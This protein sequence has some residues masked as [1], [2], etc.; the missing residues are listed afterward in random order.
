M[1]RIVQEIGLET[2]RQLIDFSGSQKVQ[3]HVWKEQLEGA[4][5]I[6]NI[7][8]REKVAYLADEVGMGKTYVALGVVGLF[9]HF[10][11]GW[12][13]LYI[14]PRENIQR[15]WHKEILNFTAN[16]WLVTDNRVRSFQRTPAYGLAV[17]HNLLDLTHQVTINPHRD[18]LTRMTSFSL[19]L[20]TNKYE[21][22]DNKRRALFQEIPWLDH[23]LFDLRDKEQFK[24]NYARAINAVLPYFDL[25]IIDEGHN[26]KHGLQGTAA[27]N[28]LI[29]QVLGHSILADR[30]FPNYG[31][32]FERVLILS[33]TPLESDYRELWNQLHLFDSHLN[34]STLNETGSDQ[35]TEEAKQAAVSRF[36]VRRLTGLTIGEKKHTKNMYRREWRNGGVSSHDHP[37][38]VADERQRLIVALV[39]KK[40][41]EIIGSERFKNSFQIGM[42]ASFESFLETAKV[43]DDSGNFDGSDQT[44]EQL[45]K[46]GIDTPSINRLAESYRQ[47]F[48]EALPHPKMDAVAESLKQNFETGEKVLI[49]V[50]R[51]RSVD[52]LAEKLN[53]YYDQWLKEYLIS[54]SENYPVIQQELEAA[55]QRYNADRL[56]RQSLSYGTTAETNQPIEENNQSV[57]KDVE[58]QGDIDNFFAWFFRGEGPSDFFSGASFNRN[59][60]TSEGSAYATFFEDNYLTW[61]LDEPDNPVQT[62]AEIRHASVEETT[63]R[64]RQAAYSIFRQSSKQQRFPR[65]RVFWAYQQAA[66]FLLEQVQDNDLAEKA[67]IIRRERYGGGPLDLLAPPGNFPDPDHFLATKTFF[68]ELVKRAQLRDRLWP[69]EP[70]DDFLA[71]FRRREQRRELLLAAARLGHPFID[72][73]LTAAHRL[74]TISAGVQ[75]RSEDRAEALINDYL[76]ILENQQQNNQ[77]HSA[78]TEL[79]K[80]AINFDLILAVNFPSIRDEPLQRLSQIFGQALGR[81]T[82]VGGMW[83]GVNQSLVRQFRMPG[84]PLILITTDVLQEGEDLHTFCGQVIHYG[85]SWTPSSME[86]RTGRVDRIQSLTQ[87]RLDN[88]PQANPHEKL[89]VYY[90]HLQETIER[91]QVERVYERMNRFIR[92]MHKS[93]AGEQLKDSQVDLTQE[94]VLQR[95]DIQPITE[96]LETIFPVKE[97]WLYRNWPSVPIKA[98]EEMER[99]LNHFIR[100]IDN[101]G[102]TFKMDIESEHAVGSFFATVFTLPDGR[103]AGPGPLPNTTRRQPFALFL[104]TATGDGRVLLRCVSPVGVVG[105]NDDQ[106]IERICLAQQKL[107]FGKICAIDDVKLNTYDLTAEADILFHPMTTQPDE[108]LDLVT[109]TTRCADYMEHALLQGRDEPMD[110]FREELVEE[111]KRE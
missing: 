100:M 9:R 11:P 6:H 65:L 41:S 86:Q 103:L 37:M 67:R 21:Q 39:Q 42:L 62:I 18:F 87:R 104:R 52:E 57:S 101:L 74:G 109:R 82:P 5:A 99:I 27:R 2:A 14:T 1:S 26:L 12:R 64:L 69:E 89:Q 54:R 22:W 59:R 83:G 75:E 68:T 24:D 95:R 66:L 58:D 98:K 35:V 32:R 31:R 10:N 110:T 93:F 72:L 17:C 91:L 55:F 107:G 43:T 85:I 60:L 23:K 15:K 97:E 49:F 30:R 94:I 81:Q 38:P 92:L 70:N 53:R 84:Y 111:P 20:P 34:W 7:L 56:C 40:V 88:Q 3:A 33:A 46:E 106:A 47:E 105:R 44:D 77:I 108:V 76:D 13:V 63:R 16:N 29:A 80:V 102:K 8:V 78:Y 45:E 79:V 36:L 4:V 51:V 48:R 19:P 25:V 73:W 90:P 61:L 28:R 50:R 71:Y 96:T